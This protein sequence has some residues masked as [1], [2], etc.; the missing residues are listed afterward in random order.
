MV[1]DTSALLAIY[2]AEP[3]SG[4]FEAAILH[5]AAAFI[6]AGTLLETAVVVEARH[7]KAGAVELDRLLK[8]LGVSTVAVDAEQV[9]AA[10]LACRKYGKGR[11]PADLNYG[12]LFAYALA[13]TTVEPLLFKCDDFSKTDVVNALTE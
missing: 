5:A 4:R 13:T 12:D 7:G 9:E 3:D 6:S 10:R 11:H 8:K 2:L 1:V